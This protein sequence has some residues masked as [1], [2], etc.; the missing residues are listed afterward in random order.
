MAAAKREVENFLKIGSM[1]DFQFAEEY[2]KI[3]R[4]ARVQ[5]PYARI[6]FPIV[7]L[8]PSA[9]RNLYDEMRA[10]VVDPKNDLF[11][12]KEGEFN[13]YRVA[14]NTQ[15]K[16]TWE[17]DLEE[18]IKTL[19]QSNAPAKTCYDTYMQFFHRVI[20]NSSKDRQKELRDVFTDVFGAYFENEESREFYFQR[21]S[22]VKFKSQFLKQFVDIVV[23]CKR[24]GE[25]HPAGAACKNPRCPLNAVA[26]PSPSPSSSPPPS[27]PPPSSSPSPPQSS[28]SLPPLVYVVAAAVIL[29]VVFNFAQ[30][31]GKTTEDTPPPGQQP[32]GYT[33][34]QETDNPPVIGNRPAP[35]YSSVRGVV[36]G[37]NVR[38]RSLPKTDST[39]IAK[40]NN[41][42][43]LTVLGFYS[44]AE[45]KY[46]WY[47]VDA[48]GQTGWMYGQ[49][50]GFH[51]DDADL[52]P[53]VA[54]D[55][56]VKNEQASPVKQ[57]AKV[58]AAE[59]K[60]E[61]QKFWIEKDWVNAFLCFNE[62][63]EL[64]PGGE[65]KTYRD[66][67]LANIK[68]G[69]YKLQG[70]SAQTMK[71][72][73][74]PEEYIMYR[75]NT[76]GRIQT[77]GAVSMVEVF[78]SHPK[79]KQTAAKIDSLSDTEEAKRLWQLLYDELDSAIRTVIS[80]KKLPFVIDPNEVKVSDAKVIDITAAVIQELKKLAR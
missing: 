5:M 73:D 59:L 16:N 31:I 28:S 70:G 14:I 43:K 60:K 42:A 58:Q 50:V 33:S 18:I 57:S 61:G 52:V 22:A 48:D 41:D 79:Y 62:A 8:K 40:Y 19:M 76:D 13:L 15:M 53:R 7:R 21:L 39:V 10:T 9:D 77:V 55:P 47:K 66:N 36:L 34:F 35:K 1:W 63:Y 24:C 26:S 37:D 67:A 29:L 46:Y 65:L 44:P 69:I 78:Y 68:V 51:G 75:T 12:Q 4:S 17:Q 49:Y 6:R 45:G 56:A 30:T 80:A 23:P 11:A 71:V 32:P 38:L 64:A 72:S 2:E 25:L 74:I 20:S 3:F 54:P 27:S